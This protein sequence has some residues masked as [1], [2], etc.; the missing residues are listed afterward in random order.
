MKEEDHFKNIDQLIRP[1]DQDIK[2]IA[3][4][5]VT[6]FNWIKKRDYITNRRADIW[7]QVERARNE[8][9][10]EMD[11]IS[12]VCKEYEDELAFTGEFAVYKNQVQTIIKKAD[13]R[14]V[15]FM[16]GLGFH[17]MIADFYEGGV[18]SYYQRAIQEQVKL[19][20][21]EDIA[22]KLADIATRIN[23]SVLEAKFMEVKAQQQVTR[24]QIMA[25]TDEKDIIDW[26]SHKA[27]WFGILVKL[28]SQDRNKMPP[29]QKMINE[30]VTDSTKD[31]KAVKELVKEGCVTKFKD[32]KFVRYNP[33][34]M[35][36]MAWTK[37]RM[38]EAKE[39]E[40]NPDAPIIAPT[41]EKVSPP[42]ENK[43]ENG[44]NDDEVYQ[45]P[46]EVKDDA[47]PEQV[48]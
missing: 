27:K 6:Q 20:N 48:V 12:Q 28:K 46:T 34:K 24:E 43:E 13:E 8:T 16:K 7:R 26:Y 35:P 30:N 33:V 44:Q 19:E 29:I 36:D 22:A 42:T 1:S 31:F 15:I 32:R 10:A 14:D 47:T 21:E 23:P 5:K 37:A 41:R 39:S 2:E 45:H 25:V 40:T 9:K 18:N 38:R 17:H 3:E 4:G 11:K